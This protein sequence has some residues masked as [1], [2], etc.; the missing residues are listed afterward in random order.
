M[1]LFHAHPIIKIA[2]VVLM[3]LIVAGT[4]IILSINER[5]DK[6]NKK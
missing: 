3:L 2:L 5:D 6:E 1:P 4:W